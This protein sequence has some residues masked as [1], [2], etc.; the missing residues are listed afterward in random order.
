MRHMDLAIQ[1]LLLEVHRGHWPA[2]P[3][4]VPL[5]RDQSRPKKLPRRMHK[6]SSSEFIASFKTAPKKVI[7]DFDIDM[8]AMWYT[9]T[10][11]TDFF[12]AVT[13]ST[14]TAFC[15]CMSFA[16]KQ[17][18][19]SYLRPSK[20]DGA[21][22][23]LGGRSWLLLVKRLRQVWPQVR[24]YL[25]SRRLRFLHAGGC[26]CGASATTCGTLSASPLG[27]SA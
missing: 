3:T 11:K 10:R 8:L 18:L 15:L 17:L 20:I 14:T 22:S 7:L 26:C 16:G 21:D 1:T 6:S 13:Q 24:H 19:V 27:T 12:H 5:Q 2:V 9:V 23:M 25:P 4:S